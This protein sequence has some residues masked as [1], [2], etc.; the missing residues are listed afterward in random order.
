MELLLWKAQGWLL[1]IKWQ[2]KADTSLPY[3]LERE[4]DENQ[5]AFPTNGQF[6]PGL[7]ACVSGIQCV[8]ALTMGGWPGK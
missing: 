6:Q 2:T 5:M 1:E 4:T 7:V 3:S 8:K